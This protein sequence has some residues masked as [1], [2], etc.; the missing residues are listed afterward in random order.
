LVGDGDFFL[1]RPTPLSFSLSKVGVG[2]FA[3]PSN[4]NKTNIDS[5]TD[6][7]TRRRRR[8]NL[9]AREDENEENEEEENEENE[10]ASL[11]MNRAHFSLWCV[12]SAPL[13]AG[14]DLR[15]LAPQLLGVLT[16]FAA[17]AVNQGFLFATQLADSS[18]DKV[19]GSQGDDDD[20]GDMDQNSDGGGG[21]NN[22]SGSSSNAGDALGFVNGSSVSQAGL[23]EDTDLWVKPLPGNQAVSSVSQAVSLL[24]FCLLR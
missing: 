19:V 6:T 12:T 8:R 9:G 1:K 7:D 4:N 10:A 15:T 23:P 3:W 11:A 14:A 21:S 22:S 16:N 2:D 5:H 24:S 20:G 18:S 17:V 13:I